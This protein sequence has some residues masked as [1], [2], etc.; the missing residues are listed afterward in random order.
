MTLCFKY[1]F[2]VLLQKA[3]KQNR[4]P[5][6]NKQ[7]IFRTSTQP[8][9]VDQPCDVIRVQIHGE[10][11]I[12][13]AG[14][15]WNGERL[16]ES[17]EFEESERVLPFFSLKIQIFF[18]VKIQIQK[19]AS[20]YQLRISICNYFYNLCNRLALLLFSFGIHLIP[21]QLVRNQVHCP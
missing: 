9:A 6:F 2:F 17:V 4:S 18:L 12:V 16:G 5:K 8:A 10:A 14:V 19:S 13:S 1:A 20:N 15:I 21:S 7:L 3:R 11:R